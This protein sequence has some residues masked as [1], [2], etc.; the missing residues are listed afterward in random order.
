MSTLLVRKGTTKRGKG[1]KR[2]KC[3]PKRKSNREKGG[4]GVTE[5]TSS[6]KWFE[7]SMGGGRKRNGHV[8]WGGGSKAQVRKRQQAGRLHNAISDFERQQKES[9]TG[10]GGSTRMGNQGSGKDQSIEKRG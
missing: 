6:P 7:T 4:R 9:K 8:S 3:T 5:K 1:P 2:K 10:R